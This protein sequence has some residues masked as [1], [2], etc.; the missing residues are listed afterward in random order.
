MKEKAAWHDVR[1]YSK[2]LRSRIKTWTAGMRL[3]SIPAVHKLT[4]LELSEPLI[5]QDGLYFSASS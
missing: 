2:K 4:A 3:V 5:A 1:Y